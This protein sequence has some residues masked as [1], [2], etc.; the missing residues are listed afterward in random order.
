MTTDATPRARGRKWMEKRQKWLRNHPLCC[1]CRDKG[2]MTLAEEVDHITPL[3]KG[4]ID[5]ESN[6]QSLCKEH[7]Q[8]KTLRDMGYKERNRFD[9]NGRVVW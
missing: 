9:G 8:A 7:H 1:E 6:Y 5:D 4:G 2:V 3:F